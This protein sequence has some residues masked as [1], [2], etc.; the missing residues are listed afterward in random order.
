MKH[1]LASIPGDAPFGIYL[2]G[3]KP[4]YRGLRNAFNGAQTTW[5]SLS[6]TQDSLEN[7]ELGAANLAAWAD[8]RQKCETCLSE[9]SKDLEILSWFVASKMH[10]VRP[11]P[12]TA[13]AL[14]MM[15]DLV[16]LSL[17]QMQPMPPPEKLKGEND[18][19]QAAEIAE[20][21]L[22][23]FVQLFGEVENSGLLNGPMTNTP[24]IADITYGKFVLA[25]KDGALDAL[26]KTV[27]THIAAETE[28]LTQKVEALQEM[29]L[30]IDRL[31]KRI[32]TYAGA[33][34][35]SAPLIGYGK[36]LVT[37]VLRAC[38]QLVAGQGFAWPGQ[39]E[40][41][42][43][44]DPAAAPQQE[45]DAA[46]AAA[47]GTAPANGQGG[48]AFNPNANIANR[49][50]A[51]VAIAQLA[52]Y[53]RST[54]PHSPICL[55][56]D[57]AVRWGNLDAGQLYREI[58]SDGSVGMSQMALMTGLESQGFADTFN[59]RK[60]TAAP[61]VEHA[62]LDTYAAPIP[63]APVAAAPIEAV[64]NEPAAQTPAAPP[65]TPQP[66]APEAGDDDPD[67]PIEDFK[68]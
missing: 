61:I 40:G 27:E 50:E 8:L 5:R 24:L 62:K 33:H 67:I 18:E 3:E 66:D 13:E 56:L 44:D 45:G 29:T 37:D 32:T 15:T 6:E 19:A 46:P 48:G 39:D 14:A 53:F 17:D 31:D 52:K 12:D 25:E 21:R 65:S 34:G 51:L 47:E 59:P 38:E 60:K 22:R 36:R 10:G 16:E 57:R 49:N 41:E 42:P 26:R 43:Q 20:L 35:Q 1:L 28:S 63:S 7:R 23:P 58:L 2:K 4:L 54:E 11:L 55:L 30:T 9:T 64:R 68:W